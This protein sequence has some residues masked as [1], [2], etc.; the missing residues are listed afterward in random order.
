V[1]GRD[2]LRVF[3]PEV[4]SR[5]RQ[6][7]ERRRVQRQRRRRRRVRPDGS[8]RTQPDHQI[9]CDGGEDDPHPKY[10]PGWRKELGYEPVEL[11]GDHPLLDGL[12]R[13]RVF[14]HAHT[15]ELKNAPDGFVNLART[16]VTEL[17][18]LAHESL[19]LAG[20]Q[21]HPEYWTEQHPAGRR[22][23]A[24]FCEWAGVGHSVR[25]GAVHE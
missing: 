22:L 11:I 9:R 14:R 21:F 6:S 20:T 12:D 24:N 19:P 17:Q 13:R 16:D 7:K 15:S 3:E 1:A 10:Q 5:R 4:N 2:I 18:Y 8:R 25:D 23:I